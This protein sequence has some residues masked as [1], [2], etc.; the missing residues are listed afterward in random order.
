MRIAPL[1]VSL[2]LPLS[3]WANCP[4]TGGLPPEMQAELLRSMYEDGLHLTAFV[5]D[6]SCVLKSEP[7]HPNRVELRF[8]LADSYRR[9]N[10]P[11]Q[12]LV[13]YQ[14]LLKESD[15]PVEQRREALFQSAMI[16]VQ[17]QRHP[18]II[19]SFDR[20]LNP[21][22]QPTPEQEALASFHSGR[23]R[24]LQTVQAK[25][26]AKGYT[27]AARRLQ[28]ADS[29]LLSAEQQVERQSLS[30]WAWLSAGDPDQAGEAWRAALDGAPE[31]S[32]EAVDQLWRLAVAQQQ[33]PQLAKASK[34]YQEVATRHP[35]SSYAAE[36]RFRHAELEDSL[37]FTKSGAQAPDRETTL[38]IIKNYDAYLQTGD[39]SFAAKAQL[40]IGALYESIGETAAAIRI[41]ETYLKKASGTEA[42]ALRFRVAN[43]YLKV[44]DSSQALKTFQAYLKS[45]DPA[46]RAAAYYAVGILQQETGSPEKL[47]EATLAYESAR[48]LDAGY[49]QDAT[50]RATLLALYTRLGDQEAQRRLLEEEVSASGSPEQRLES[51]YKLLALLYQRGDCEGVLQRLPEVPADHP[52]RVELLFMRG[53]CHF[54]AKRWEETLKDLRPLRGQA[55]HARESFRMRVFALRQLGRWEELAEEFS[56]ARRDRIDTLTGDDY[57][58][59]IFAHVQTRHWKEADLVYQN[60]QRLAPLTV[61]TP[62][63][64]MDWANILEEI[65]DTDRLERHYRD[66]LLRS[67]AADLRVEVVRRLETLYGKMGRY[68]RLALLYENELLPLQKRPEERRNTM[69]TLAQLCLEHLPSSGC[70]EV[71]LQ[72]T[73]E[74][75][76]SEQELWAAWTLA[77]L[78]ERSARTDE[79]LKTLKSLEQRPLSGVWQA[80]V[81]FQ[82]ASLQQRKML[83]EQALASYR[84][85]L[86]LSASEPPV[87]ELKQEAQ[88]QVAILEKNQ[89]DQELQKL[90]DRKD[91]P[92]VAKMLR[93]DFHSGK[94]ERTQANVRILLDA[95]IQS[96]NWEAVSGTIREEVLSGRQKLDDSLFQTLLFAE[97]QKAGTARG[98][99]LLEAY[100]LLAQKQPEKAN[101]V[102]ML[103]EQAQAA[104]SVGGRRKAKDAYERA[105]EK[106][107]KNDLKTS[108]YIVGQLER[109]YG[110]EN[111][112]LGKAELYEQAHQLLGGSEEYAKS[113]RAYAF[114]LASLLLN[115]LKREKLGMAWMEKVDEGGTSDEELYAVLGMVSFEIQQQ[116]L[117]DAGGRLR[118]TINRDVAETSPY[119]PQLHFQYAEVLQRREEWKLALEQYRLV[120]KAPENANSQAYRATAKQRADEIQAYL[121]SL[122]PPSSQNNG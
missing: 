55:Q 29:K 13:N 19:Q 53:D 103:I 2:T 80:K 82:T 89:A 33:R 66:L 48:K 79:A 5:E 98:E 74:G 108:L 95:E 78:Q 39:A 15:V 104:E 35:K 101:S 87:P 32:K 88:A 11:E 7:K 109:L 38:R 106:S 76:T 50:L 73:D 46:H 116:K 72:R 27:D 41:Y 45:G 117:D 69:F 77:E 107:G 71:W 96:G 122:N 86:E 42:E 57:R 63:V 43:L 18:E 102:P 51:E 8:Q 28:Q 26:S 70:A 6:A 105:L 21:K 68:D 1:F 37:A 115:D 22:E 9:L 58:L 49:R 17:A 62:E 111:N 85:V 64:L 121:D 54:K 14:T 93:E 24:Y 23:S 100:A 75:G 34:L 83:W 61:G 60:W 16:H 92:G 31:N 90:I 120:L 110:E 114:K 65:G 25:G 84:K 56:R 47:Q 12:A 113:R 67:E 20:L 94:R 118:K 97:N 44:G 10:Q 36:S 119:F 52:Q 81:W 40:R 112:A 91:W 59:W 4:M 3:I 30:G 99:G